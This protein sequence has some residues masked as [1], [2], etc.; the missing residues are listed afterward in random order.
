MRDLFTIVSR[1]HWLWPRYANTPRPWSRCHCGDLA[2]LRAEN[3]TD[4]CSPCLY[5]G[6][7]SCECSSQ[8]EPPWPFV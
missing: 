4:W 2:E 3:G 7:D 5:A 8:P 6:H 1:L